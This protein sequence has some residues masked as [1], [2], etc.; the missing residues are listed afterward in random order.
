MPEHTEAVGAVNGG[1]FHQIMIDGLQTGKDHDEHIG[2]LSP[3]H[4]NGH[5]AQRRGRV[6][7]PFRGGVGNQAET[8]QD[9]VDNTV[10]CLEQP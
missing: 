6:Q 2:G 5:H 4:R 10:L 7:H 3:D 9:I 1:R 8:V